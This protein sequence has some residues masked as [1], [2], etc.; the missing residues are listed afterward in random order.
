MKKR[1]SMLPIAV[2]T[3]ALALS[4]SASACT[5]FLV[6]KDATTDGSTIATH[7]D[8][9]TSADFR[10]WLTPSMK[11]GEGMKRDLVVD[12]HNYGD[13]TNF[14]EVKDYGN[15][16]AV[17]EIDQPEDTYAYFHSRYSFLNE[18]GVAMG[19][20]TFS[21]DRGTEH[22]DKVME[23]LF[24]SNNGII[25][26]WNAQD[27]ALERAS[28]A[29]EAV[30][31]MGELCET[32]LWKDSGETINICDGNECWVFEAYGLDLW[33][34]VR[35]P[36]NAF[37]V[38]ANR[39]RIN[40]FDFEDTENYLCS[41]NLKSFAE[42]N[43]L[44]SADSGEEFSPAQAYG[45]CANEYCSLREW[46]AIDLVAPSLGV[47]VTT[48][49]Y[50]LYVVPEEK[51]SVQDVF[52]LAGDYY[53]GTE[54]DVSMTAYAGDYG[55]PLNINNPNRP[56]NM[57]RTCYVM[58]ANI[59]SWLP[60][61]VKCLVWH[62]YGAP[63]STFLTP[64]WASQTAMPELYDHGSRY[65]LKLDRTAG[66]WIASYVQ[67]AA[68]SNYDYAIEI[69]KERRSERMAAQYEEVA[70]L[71][72][73]WA[74]RIENG[75]TDA[76]VAELTDYACKTAEEWYEIWLDLGDELMGRLMWDIVEFRN[77][78]YSDWY[79]EVLNAAPMKPVEEEVETEAK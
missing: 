11:G 65:D 53:E 63:D 77:P 44:W 60:D 27:I 36:D 43:G 62:G 37:F 56:I 32:Y 75:E 78:G 41:P 9:S 39:A 23:V 15:G 29:R 17:A 10:L 13:F 45:P 38:A 47:E 3:S 24:G 59:K 55:N 49:T 68:T 54:Y 48:G 30:E 40:E 46:R 18:K 50:P 28:T 4:P 33:A 14:P 7:N 8:D 66:W 6:G 61:E 73:E 76:V 12:S 5:T 52:E 42:E 2:M 51:L 26:C 22:A 70:K 79:K 58:L 21:Y 67:Q 35:I 20:S 64:L 19:E 34:A 69:I 57:F 25:D 71:Q 72:E 74:A 16:Y 31:I 1:L